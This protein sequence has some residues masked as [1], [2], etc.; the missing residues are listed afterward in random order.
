MK[1]HIF[2]YK[3][4]SSVALIEFDLH[5]GVLLTNQEPSRAHVH[6]IGR[7]PNGNDYGVD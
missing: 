1:V 3:V 4:H 5:P 7:T 2:Y 6:S